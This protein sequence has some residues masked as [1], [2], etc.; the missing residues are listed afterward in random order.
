MFKSER[1]GSAA[2]AG[3]LVYQASQSYGPGGRKL[4]TV[5]SGPTNDLF[6]DDDEDENGEHKKRRIK[7]E[8]GQEGDLDELD[9]EETFADDEEK[10]EN[11]AEDEEEKELEVRL[12]HA[13]CVAVAILKC[14]CRNV[15][16]ASTKPRTKRG[17]G[18]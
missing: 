4:R 7:K 10:I 12:Y 9:F 13:R 3:P 5:V 11:E 6:G 17:R 1:E 2:P 16:S 8:F 15:S 18:T 14:A